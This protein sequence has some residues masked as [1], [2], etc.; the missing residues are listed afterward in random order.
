MKES[1]AAILLKDIELLIASHDRLLAAKKRITD[2]SMR[3]HINNSPSFAAWL[4]F[5][6]FQTEDH[7]FTFIKNACDKYEVEESQFWVWREP[8]RDDPMPE[9][10]RLLV[11]IDM[12]MNLIAQNTQTKVPVK[13]VSEYGWGPVDQHLRKILA[14]AQAATDLE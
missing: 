3:E 13:S 7:I 12:A 9:V 2:P 8:D 4:Y 5:K 10:D 6:G 14:F 11:R 1:H